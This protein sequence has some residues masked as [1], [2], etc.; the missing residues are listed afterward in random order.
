MKEKNHIFAK[1][2]KELREA[3]GFTQ[4]M[5]ADKLGLTR[6]GVA[7]YEAIDD[8]KIPREARLRKIANIFDCSIDYLLG[9]T[10]DPT[11]P[12]KDAPIDAPVDLYEILN[13]E[14]VFKGKPIPRKDLD[15]F[16]DYLTRVHGYLKNKD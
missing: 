3:K 2:F 11:P 6:S 5:I 7:N 9:E 13:D 8:P 4:Q 1:R 12:K 16:I 10:D 14:P 15:F